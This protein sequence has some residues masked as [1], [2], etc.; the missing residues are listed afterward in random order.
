MRTLIEVLGDIYRH[1][2]KYPDDDDLIRLVR[3][4]QGVPV[5]YMD[6]ESKLILDLFY[7]DRDVLTF[8]FLHRLFKLMRD[9]DYGSNDVVKRIYR[10][11]IKIFNEI[12]INIVNDKMCLTEADCFFLQRLP[13][14]QS[15]SRLVDKIKYHYLTYD[16]KA[17][18]VSKSVEPLQIEQ[19]LTVYIK[20]KMN[21]DSVFWWYCRQ[22]KEYV[23]LFYNP[24]QLQRPKFIIDFYI[25]LPE[26]DDREDE[27]EEKFASIREAMVHFDPSISHAPAQ[28]PIL[29]LYMGLDSNIVK[30]G[31]TKDNKGRMLLYQYPIQ[32]EDSRKTR[33]SVDTYFTTGEIVRTIKWMH[34]FGTYYKNVSDEN[35][36]DKARFFASETLFKRLIYTYM[37]YFGTD[38]EP[39]QT[40]QQPEWFKFVD[41]ATD[42]SKGYTLDVLIALMGMAISCIGACQKE[43]KYTGQGV[44]PYLQ[45]Y[46]LN[47]DSEKSKQR[48]YWIVATVL[49]YMVFEEEQMI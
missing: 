9:A 35:L 30:M 12:N 28:L 36:V 33:G 14:C 11:V 4:F 38:L 7:T 6:D 16:I 2:D 5:E 31:R 49:E 44:N 20:S 19:N 29:Y 10:G 1:P 48:L 46:K 23:W 40:V 24:M 18:F 13:K 26:P 34:S 47:G 32:R 22:L 37:D 42:A 8:Q 15:H 39:C 21:T 45:Y 17:P 27:K 25:W 43:F 41:G 3:E